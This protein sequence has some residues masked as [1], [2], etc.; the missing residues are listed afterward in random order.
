MK[1]ICMFK[2]FTRA[3]LCIAAIGVF[4]SHALSATSAPTGQNAFTRAVQKPMENIVTPVENTHTTICNSVVECRKYGGDLQTIWQMNNNTDFSAKD[5]PDNCYTLGKD[6]KY[7]Y[8]PATCT[9][10]NH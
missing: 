6:G 9:H 1:G 8:S 3:V 2:Q 4:A 5:Y 7:V 10:P